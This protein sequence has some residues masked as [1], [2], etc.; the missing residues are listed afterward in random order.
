[1]TSEITIAK[2][3]FSV[4]IYAD[5]VI[6]NYDNIIFSI[7]SPQ[8]KQKQDTGPKTVKVIDL[9]RV[10]HTIV[11]QGYITPTATKTA[12]Q[13]KSDLISLFKGAGVTGSAATVTYSSHPD[14][15]LSMFLE[16]MTII[17]QPIDYDPGTSDQEIM[18]YTVQIDLI[19]GES[20]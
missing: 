3:A 5:N 6:E 8:T 18:K 17:E 11:L 7:K 15:P 14:S 13:V 16:K 19:E 20:A 4:I 10:T 12:D 1:M 2:G 9:L